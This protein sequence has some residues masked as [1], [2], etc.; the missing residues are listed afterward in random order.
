MHSV[1]TKEKVRCYAAGYG[2]DCD[3]NVKPR[4]AWG[5]KMMCNKHGKTPPKPEK[6]K[7]S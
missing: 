1:L 3:N 2:S 7:K 5:G 6:G 4:S